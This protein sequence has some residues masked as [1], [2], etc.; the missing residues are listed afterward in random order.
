MGGASAED[1][2]REIA[3]GEPFVR[4]VARARSVL[5]RIAH[6]RRI[7]GQKAIHWSRDTVG[8]PRIPITTH[9]KVSPWATASGS[10]PLVI[11]KAA[12]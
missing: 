5:K 8:G 6:A 10:D 4:R 2:A 9:Y 1:I 12:A 7:G 11:R 3:T